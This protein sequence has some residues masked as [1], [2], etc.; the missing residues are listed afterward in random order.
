MVDYAKN[1][2]FVSTFKDI[3][4][5]GYSGTFMAGQGILSKLQR[6][7]QDPYEQ[8]VINL[9][10]MT[11]DHPFSSINDA[12][13]KSALGLIER[14]FTREMLPTLFPDLILSAAIYVVQYGDVL[15]QDNLQNVFNKL[16]SNYKNFDLLRYIRIIY[17]YKKST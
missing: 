8:Y 5:V 6:S 3:E 1:P 10:T 16:G 15:N 2:Q 11:N 7:V 4:R 14:T 13:K 9:K 12:T 17:R